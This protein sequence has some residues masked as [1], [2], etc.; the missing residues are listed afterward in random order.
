MRNTL[1]TIFFLLI[2]LHY[3]QRLSA[4]FIYFGIPEDITEVKGSDIIIINGI[5]MKDTLFSNNGKT[6]IEELNNLLLD[7]SDYNIEIEVYT[8]KSSEEKI[9]NKI[10]ESIANNIWLH[11]TELNNSIND[12]VTI[13]PRG[14]SKPLLEKEKAE[15]YYYY[16]WINNRLE[17][18]VKEK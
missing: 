11:L 4:Q 3:C 7:L 6:Q 8:F 18:I 5:E 15:N 2:L 9:N 17:I 14:N 1:I 12:Y 10:S 16:Y 13:T